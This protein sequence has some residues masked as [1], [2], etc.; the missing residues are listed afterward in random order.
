MIRN[1]KKNNITGLTKK[2][3]KNSFAKTMHFMPCKMLFFLSATKLLRIK[4]SKTISS[5]MF[6]VSELQIKPKIR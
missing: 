3:Y 6:S 4:C 1:Y 2:K 5:S